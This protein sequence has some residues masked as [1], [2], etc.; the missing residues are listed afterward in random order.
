MLYLGRKHFLPSHERNSYP[1]SFSGDIF[2]LFSPAI[3]FLQPE[4]EYRSG[5]PPVDIRWVL[6]HDPKGRVRP[7]ALLCT[8]VNLP[9]SQI[10]GLFVCR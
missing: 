8:D 6:V 7:L 1:G 10:V 3:L 4:H 2:G 9:V 5:K